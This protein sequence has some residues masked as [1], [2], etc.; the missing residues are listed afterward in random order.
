MPYTLKFSDLSKLDTIVVP[1]MPPGI[2]TVDTSLSLVGRGYPN[3]GQ[4]IA[5]NFLHL[6]E[7]FASALPPENPIEGQLWYDTSDPSNKVLRIMDGTATA[8]RWPSANGIY[9]QGVDPTNSATAG[10]KIGDIWVDTANNQLKIFNSNE[11]TV[12]GPTTSGTEKTGSE[13]SII[14]DVL[15]LERNVIKNWTGG[16]VVSILAKETFTP[17]QVIDGFTVIVPGLNLSTKIFA[18]GEPTPGINGVAKFAKNLV[19]SAGNQFSV[20]SYLRKNDQTIPGPNQGQVITGRL[21]FQTPTDTISNELPG[22]GRDGVV[23]HNSSNVSDTNYIQLYKGLNDA[24]VLNNTPSGKILFKT[25]GNSVSTTLEVT[26]TQVTVYQDLV[27]SRNLTVANTLTIASTSSSSLTVSGGIS[28]S[29]TSTFLNDVNVAG[30]VS[31]D[32]G[33]VVGKTIASGAVITPETI[34]TQDIGTPSKYFRWVYASAIGTSTSQTTVYGNVTGSAGLLSKSTQFKL[35]GPISSNTITYNGGSSTATFTTQV[36]P[37]I[38][39]SQNEATETTSSLSLLVLN[40]ATSQ[41]AKITRDVF[42]QDL[43]PTGA[44]ILYPSSTNIPNGWALCDGSLQSTTGEYQ[45]LFQ[46]IGWSYSSAS[47]GS[48]FNLPNIVTTATGG[49]PVYHIIKK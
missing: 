5:E 49:Y 10:L 35:S 13:A 7:N 2:N 12:V 21:L 17:K 14:V 41:L 4:K 37:T 25:R 45:K 40:T 26:P 39:S 23:I 3:Y 20:N 18:P 9:Q 46:V 16:Q 30:V 43:V 38:I 33:M 29:N 27:A 31:A 34:G 47:G 6:L 28:V 15:N 42:L 24:I 32:K 44:M 19:D 8:A 11:W 22:R 36:N 48:T 1:D